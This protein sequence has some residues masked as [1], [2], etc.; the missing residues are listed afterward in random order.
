MFP[1]LNWTSPRD[2]AWISATQSLKCTSPFDVFLLLK[3]SDF[4]NH[5]L[6]HIYEQCIDADERKSEPIQYDLILKKWYDLQPSMEFRCFVKNQEIIG[7]TQRD[8]TF[9]PFLLDIK[10]DI[11]HSI[12]N[13]F[14]D[15]IR[16]NFESVHCNVLLNLPEHIN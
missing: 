9:Y 14:E 1:K 16:D 7:I 11:E 10:Q 3:S 15:V 5:D 8:V 13:F 12:Y 6:N 2:A 4:I